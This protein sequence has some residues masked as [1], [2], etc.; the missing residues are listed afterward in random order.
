LRI[1]SWNPKSLETFKGNEAS[2]VFCGKS[3][4]AIR[5]LTA[6]NLPQLQGRV[7]D[8]H[9]LGCTPDISQYAQFDWYEPVLYWDPV[10]SF[11]YEQ[12]LFGRWI[13]VA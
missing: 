1:E 9:V 12:K 2:L 4:T 13:G 11:P 7:P 6:L 10:G 3:V 8:E 5:R